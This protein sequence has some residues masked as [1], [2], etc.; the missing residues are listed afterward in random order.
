MDSAYLKIDILK[1]YLYFYVCF[2]LHNE[3]S[4]YVQSQM[5]NLFNGNFQDVSGLFNVYYKDKICLAK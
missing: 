2:G 5:S 4:K 1:N 3:H